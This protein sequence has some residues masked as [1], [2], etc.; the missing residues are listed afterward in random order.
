MI[1]LST[2]CL[3]KLKLW[4]VKKYIIAAQENN[5]DFV[6][7]FLPYHSVNPTFYTFELTAMKIFCQPLI[8]FQLPAEN[9]IGCAH[10]EY[11]Y[12]LG[13]IKV[14]KKTTIIGQR[15]KLFVISH[16]SSN[17]KFNSLTSLLSMK[18]QTRLWW[19][20][21]SNILKSE[22]RD[23]FLKIEMVFKNGNKI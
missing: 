3:S 13:E 18:K 2:S 17:K 12:F 20:K 1:F 7:L 14:C 10:L 21:S 23:S 6:I 22:V 16:I 15:K 5:C 11:V 8:L 4:N 9:H 19:S